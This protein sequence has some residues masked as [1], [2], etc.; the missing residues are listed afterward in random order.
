VIHIISQ[1]PA[2][3]EASMKFPT[4]IMLYYMNL[5]YSNSWVKCLKTYELKMLFI[6]V[7]YHIGCTIGMITN[8]KITDVVNNTMSSS[9]SLLHNQGRKR[10][11]ENNSNKNIYNYPDSIAINSLD[12]ADGLKKLLTKYGF[13]LNEL[14]NMPSSELAEFLGIDKYVAQII[15][16]AATKQSNID[17]TSEKLQTKNYITL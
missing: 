2:N 16:R 12:I 15:G 8:Y 9:R 11:N 10:I 1:L 3:Y 14:L 7:K 4:N 17:N 6:H 5:Q 13:T